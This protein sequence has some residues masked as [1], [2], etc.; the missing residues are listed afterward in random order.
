MRELCG[1]SCARL[2][3]RNGEALK[4]IWPDGGRFFEGD[5]LHL[6]AVCSTSITH[7]AD[8]AIALRLPS[9]QH[10]APPPASSPRCLKRP[11]AAAN[12]YSDPHSSD[13]LLCRW[14]RPYSLYDCR[15]GSLSQCGLI[16]GLAQLER[17]CHDW[18]DTWIVLDARFFV[19]V[20]TVQSTSL[21]RLS[22]MYESGD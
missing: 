21:A 5:S 10:A 1:R 2:S 4:S 15:R 17:R 13:I 7:H 12:P 18:M 20:S 19:H 6:L 14:T 8:T 22:R 9:R 16:T 3:C 11:R